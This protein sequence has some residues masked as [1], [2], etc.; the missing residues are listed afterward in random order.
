MSQSLTIGAEPLP[1][2]TLNLPP[3]I[4]N[5]IL[6]EDIVDGVSSIYHKH[7]HSQ[8]QADYINFIVYLQVR[9]GLTSRL[10][11]QKNWK[12]LYS[13]DAHGTSLT[14]LYA[15]VQ[16]GLLRSAGGCLLCIRDMRGGTYGAY[17]N[18]AFR[19]QENYYGNGDW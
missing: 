8:A 2:V 16:A 9:A 12:L 6:N 4:S 18:E 10:R 14:T 1:S 5:T 13:L 19:K 7:Y 11:L 17:V 3:G 15:K